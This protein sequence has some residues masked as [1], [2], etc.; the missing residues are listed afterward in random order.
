MTSCFAYVDLNR[1][2]ATSQMHPTNARKTFPCFDEPAMKA[3]FHITVL[4]KR[5]TVALSN[6]KEVGLSKSTFILNS[7]FCHPRLLYFCS[8]VMFMF[9][10]LSKCFYLKLCNGTNTA[11]TLK[12]NLLAV[13]NTT[14]D[15]QA[16]TKTTFEPTAKM[17]TY[18]LALVVSDYEYVKSNASTLVRN[19]ILF[20]RCSHDFM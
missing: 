17:S 7:L 11:L 20:L 3:V 8:Y 9:I 5:G 16:V 13:E 1:V 14:V 15:G 6:G 18:L 10:T 4:H 2:V 12:L 19:R